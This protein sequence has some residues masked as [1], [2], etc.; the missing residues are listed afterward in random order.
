MILKKLRHESLWLIITMYVL[1]LTNTAWFIYGNVLYYQNKDF[2]G[3]S[4]QQDS[5]PERTS[6]M[7]IMVLIGYTTMCK[8]C[9]L[10]SLLAYLVPLLIQV[11]RQ[12]NNQGIPGLLKKLKK[13]KIKM[14]D[15]E[16]EDSSKQCSICFE[17]YVEN[18][19]V[20]TLPCDTRHMFQ[21][22]CISEWL[23]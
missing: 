17:D 7:W 15:L 9:C 22:S 10:S 11:Y 4:E 19:E 14:S 20:V 1:L 23:K 13:G 18:D 3:D 2:C 12:Q 21:S 8:C 6:A 5:S 16:S